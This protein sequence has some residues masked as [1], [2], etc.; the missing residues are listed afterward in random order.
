MGGTPIRGQSNYWVFKQEADIKNPSPSKAWVFIDEHER[1][2]NDGWFAVDM[3]G[4]WGIFD[5]PA[6]RHNNSYALSFA[7]GHAEIWKLTD[8]RTINWQSRPIS[9]N[10]RNRD[11]V[12]LQ[13]ASTSLR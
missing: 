11:W 4:D 3:V 9:N 7:D 2:I 8:T 1:S 5:V 12:A 10:P 13:A 6:T